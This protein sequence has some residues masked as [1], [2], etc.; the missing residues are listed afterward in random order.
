[1]GWH[2]IKALLAT[3]AMLLALVPAAQP[4][5]AALETDRNK[6]FSQAGA[7]AGAL[8]AGDQFGG[9][10]ATGDFNGDGF[11]DVLVGAPSENVGSASSAGG[12]NVIYGGSVGLDTPDNA[13]FTQA[14]LPGRAE[15]GDLLGL[16]VAAGDFNN[17]GFDD[18]AIG[19]PGEGIGSLHAAGVVYI[20]SGSASGLTA[21]GA[22]YLSQSGPMAGASEADDKFGSALAVGD[23]NGD[24]FADLAIAAVHED[25]GSAVDA[26]AVTVV[27]GSAAGLNPVNSTLV[28]QFGPVASVA[29]TDDAFGTAVAFGDFDADGFDD[30]VVGVPYE[31]V[32]SL[33]DS[34]VVHV[35]PGSGQGLDIGRNVALSQAGSIAGAPE[36]EDYFGRSL[37]TGDFDGD[38]F[39][40]LVVG[41]PG[42]DV[43]S[44]LGAGAVNLLFGSASGIGALRNVA[45]SQNGPVGGVSETNDFFGRALTA[46][47]FNGDG[48]DDV[49]IGVPGE[50][51][52]GNVSAGAV[53]TLYGESFFG[54][55]TAG[56]E[57]FSARGAV[58][59]QPTANE[60][61]GASLSGADFDNDG[62]AD[63]VYGIPGAQDR[64]GNIGILYGQSDVS[65]TTTRVSVASGGAQ[66]NDHSY[67]P[68]ISADGTHVAFTSDASN[69]GSSDNYGLPD[70]YVADT[71]VGTTVR[72]SVAFD[73]SLANDASGEADL[74][75]NGDLVVFSSDASN[76]V[77][78]DNPGYQDIF[79]RNLNTG[80]TQK[81][82]VG[83]NGGQT[84]GDSSQPTISA[85][86]RYVSFVSW[87]TNL[88]ANDT[89]NASDVFVLDRQTGNL[90][91]VSVRANGAQGNGSSTEA[92]ISDD[93][94]FIAFASQA[95]NLVV[96]DTNGR[97]DIFVVGV[98]SLQPERVS[99]S[100]SGAQSGLGSFAPSI[101][102]NGRVVAFV[103]A[104][105]NL[106]SGD[107][108]LVPDVFVHDR[109]SGATT[110][111]S[112]ASAGG[113]GNDVS[114]HPSI[115]GDGRYVAFETYA[116]NLVSGD[117]NGAS[118]VLV[119]DR[120]TG[121]T[122]LVSQ[123]S[124]GAQGNDFSGEPALAQTGM[125]LVFTSDATNL[126][127]GDSNGSS[128]VFRHTV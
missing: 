36:R 25:I 62:S 24:G 21:S 86:G 99:V 33:S 15:A 66:A 81:L 79:L 78:G 41:A 61:L 58:A 17:D 87:A 46:A 20:V 91:R 7:V 2:R 94:T 117:N 124:A 38:G 100:S 43:G 85:N 113:Q 22:E 10:V 125:G 19:A 83:V 59:G 93:G 120:D 48:T 128:D 121:R 88:V 89:N 101:S 29:E 35:I 40:D 75:G 28:S 84:D 127:P 123:S 1:M 98:T 11:G 96:G 14:N 49:A 90:W 47:D 54:L 27:L 57:Q 76:L 68:A 111:V 9:A 82:T 104:S 3:A 103:S 72:A 116:S 39:A 109:P 73:G 56:S 13:S 63:L 6:R 64:A 95:P 4:V 44:I 110:R 97:A 55:S 122:H 45:F 32:G 118:D 114:S 70:V 23:V 60:E 26:G 12:F 107:N 71:T 18:A 105:G 119:H 8:E 102:S 65:G 50:T 115:G 77:Q 92:V 30:L 31:D 37:A 67:D 74:S 51:V 106:V 34:G 5:D 126:V 42:E 112:V 16:A 69:V 52:F 108:N 53:T 80:V